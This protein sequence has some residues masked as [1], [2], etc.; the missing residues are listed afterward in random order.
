MIAA[1]PSNLSLA[2]SKTASI[3]TIMIIIHLLETKIS[4]KKGGNLRN[5]C[6]NPKLKGKLLKQLLKMATK[7]LTQSSQMTTW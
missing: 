2:L 1:E 5:K 6:L 4:Y 3:S 7:I